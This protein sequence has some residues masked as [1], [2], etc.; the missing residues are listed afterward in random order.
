MDLLFDN[1]HYERV[2]FA[3]VVGDD[4]HADTASA[5]VFV[6]DIEDFGLGLDNWIE[7]DLD[8]KELASLVLLEV[9]EESGE[10]ETLG[11]SSDM[12]VSIS[13]H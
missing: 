4:S 1:T 13:C 11:Y 6:T 9:G 7:D 5:F 8:E 3:E 2:F 12:V 10:V